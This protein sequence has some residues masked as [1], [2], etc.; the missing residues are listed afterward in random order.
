MSPLTVRFSDTERYDIYQDGDVVTLI[1][2]TGRG[3][4][5]SEIPKV[6]GWIEKRRQFKEKVIELM[7]ANEEPGEISFE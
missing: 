2:T 7:Q 5:W 6:K 1:A 4:F 3:S